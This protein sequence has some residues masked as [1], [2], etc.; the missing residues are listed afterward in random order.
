VGIYK[1]GPYYTECGEMTDDKKFGVVLYVL[2][3]GGFGEKFFS[4]FFPRTE[5]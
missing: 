5:M 4:V 1:K 2:L 3:V